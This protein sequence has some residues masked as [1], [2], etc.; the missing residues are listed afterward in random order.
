MV[1][2]VIVSSPGYKKQTFFGSHKKLS[3]SKLVWKSLQIKKYLLTSSSRARKC[4]AKF[5]K[6]SI[7]PFGLL[8]K[9]VEIPILFKSFFSSGFND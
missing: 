8:H 3:L 2:W 7:W 5:S 6:M 9:T 1:S 4:L